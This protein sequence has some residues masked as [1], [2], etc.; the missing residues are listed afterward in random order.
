MSM[1]MRRTLHVDSNFIVQD[2]K[3]ELFEASTEY[4][5]PSI[6]STSGIMLTQFGFSETGK[7]T[8]SVVIEGLNFFPIKP[9]PINFTATVTDIS[10][11]SS[12]IVL[13]S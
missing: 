9:L 2:D 3:K 11:G 1:I 12:H 13:S 10:D 8:V 6:H 5:Q 4:G 7:Y